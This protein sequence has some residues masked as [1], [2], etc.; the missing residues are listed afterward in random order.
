MLPETFAGLEL[1]LN[2][3]IVNQTLKSILI[4][5]L[6]GSSAKSDLVDGRFVSKNNVLY[7][8]FRMLTIK[9]YF[10]AEARLK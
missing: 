8:N 2:K 7:R 1:S 4:V 10:R 5:V 3:L 6:H 9:L